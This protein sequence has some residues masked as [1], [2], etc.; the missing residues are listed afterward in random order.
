[1]QLHYHTTTPP[2]HPARALELFL[3]DIV[4]E[5]TTIAREQGSKKVMPYHV[6]RLAAMNRTYDFL[7]DMLAKYNDPTGGVGSAGGTG[8][9][10]EQGKK[11][12]PP[13]KG[14]KQVKPNE[15]EEEDEEEEET[16]DEEAE[17]SG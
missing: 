2:L 5:S 14:K 16:E 11:I 10:A 13:P 12:K 3:R 1:M 8:S 6:K 9:T 7:D 17:E 4:L 15:E